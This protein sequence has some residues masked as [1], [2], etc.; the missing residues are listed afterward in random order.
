MMKEVPLI[1]PDV[2]SILPKHPLPG[3]CP[4]T[5]A[6]GPFSDIFF[7]LG[8]TAALAAGDILAPGPHKGRGGTSQRGLLVEFSRRQGRALRGRAVLRGRG[9]GGGLV[10]H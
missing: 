6:W 8:A 3:D 10:L 4:A 1:L 9:Q 7:V 2:S 5:F